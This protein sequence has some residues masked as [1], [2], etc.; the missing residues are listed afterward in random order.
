MYGI[1]KEIARSKITVCCLQEVRYLDTGNKLIRLD[2][3]ENFKLYWCGKKKRR[4]LGVAVLIKDDPCIIVEEPDVNDPRIMALNITVYGFKI[5]LVNA[6][7]PT[8]EGNENQKNTFYRN[9][10]KACKTESK[11]RKL[12]IAGD[13]NATTSISMKH[14]SYDWTKI[15]EDQLCNDNGSRIKSFC[16]KLHLCMPQTYFDHPLNNRY[17]WYS[18]DGRTKKVLDY[19]LTQSFVQQF[20]ASCDVNSDLNIETDHR[21]LSTTIIPPETKKARRKPKQKARK[22][23]LDLNALNNDEVKKRFA[24]AVSEKLQIGVPETAIGKSN[25]IVKCLASAAESIVPKQKKKS[26]VN[27]MWKNDALLNSLLERR[28][29]TVNASED[30]KT[31]TKLIKKRVLRLKN[32]KLEIEAQEINSFANRQCVRIRIPWKP[33]A[34]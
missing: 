11:H 20:I 21:L 8:E 2:N 14:C 3:G 27:E 5:R 33:A 31:Y 16:R 24:M 32:E 17:T 15:V 22:E 19:I 6:Y 10:E 26:N 18:N 28:R 4:D 23:K 13:F 12:I 1:T 29:A 30:Y 9:L 34:M 7:S 25:N